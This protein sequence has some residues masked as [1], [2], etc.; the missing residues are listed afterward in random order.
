MLTR[1]WDVA[2]ILFSH[3]LNIAD[4]TTINLL[5]TTQKDC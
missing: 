3:G 5:V 1:M 2:N 4:K